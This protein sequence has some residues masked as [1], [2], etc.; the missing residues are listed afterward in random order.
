MFL[1]L[2]LATVGGV[3]ETEKA[4]MRYLFANVERPA[5]TAVLMVARQMSGCQYKRL[6]AL[7]AS[8]GTVDTWMFLEE[9]PSTWF[10]EM[11]SAIPCE[12]Q[13]GLSVDRYFIGKHDDFIRGVDFKLWN[14]F[15]RKNGTSKVAFIHFLL[16]SPYEYA[17]YIEDDAFFTG[18]WS[19][20]FDVFPPNH[21]AV[22]HETWANAS[23]WYWNIPCRVNK[24]PECAR[25]NSLLQWFW[26]T[27]RFSKKFM[28]SFVDL[29]ESETL[30]GHCEA[31]AP[32]ACEM[33]QCTRH[34]LL[35]YTNPRGFTA[36][37]LTLD[38][39]A[40]QWT[41]EY[42]ANGTIMQNYL[43]HPVKCDADHTL[44]IRQLEWAGIFLH[45]SHTHNFDEL[46]FL[47]TTPAA[48]PYGV[49]HRV[50]RTA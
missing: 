38:E 2:M 46:P 17:W 39:Q 14:G 24:K 42:T 6:L 15:E 35:P 18:S 9:V 8:A 47:A 29:V 22:V 20:F 19:N 44:G 11:Y 45:G 3:P 23:K 26:F 34:F 7:A 10:N 31:I 32:L 40:E 48:V 13:A 33:T 37:H 25:F 12:Y 36:G 41:L 1:S 30:Y 16:F 4:R 49:R 21:D 28:H 43:Y 27:A 5:Q 50:G